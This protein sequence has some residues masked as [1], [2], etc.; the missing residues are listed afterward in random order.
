VLVRPS[1][2]SHEHLEGE[3]KAN[4]NTCQIRNLRIPIT[5]K[6]ITFSNRNKNTVSANDVFHVPGLVWSD[7]VEGSRSS[8]YESQLTNHGNT[9][10]SGAN[11]RDNQILLTPTFQRAR[12]QHG[13]SFRLTG[14]ESRRR[15]PDHR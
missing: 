1:G 6:D 2:K 9:I 10:A 7:A 15:I 4:R 12:E 3:E 14:T 8:N 13:D 11:E 5:T